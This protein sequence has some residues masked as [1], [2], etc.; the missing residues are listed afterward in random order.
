MDNDNVD[1]MMMMMTMIIF[2]FQDWSPPCLP[3]VPQAFHA[4]FP[5]LVKS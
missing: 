1:I 3:W 5:V 2:P 4:R